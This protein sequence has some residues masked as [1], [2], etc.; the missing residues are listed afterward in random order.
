MTAE[1]FKALWDSDPAAAFQAFIVGLAQMDEE[2][3]S[4]IAT[5]QEI[6]VA[7]IRLRDTLLRAVNANELFSKAQEMANIAWDENTAPHRRGQQALRD[8]GIE[9]HQP[10]KHRR[11]GRPAGRGRPEPDD[12]GTHRRR[13]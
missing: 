1:Q 3:I 12:T 11:T 7:E 8:H 2:G 6:G 5:L 13:E 4:A 9:A 10:Q